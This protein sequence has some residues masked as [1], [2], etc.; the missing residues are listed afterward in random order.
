M[1]R[2]PPSSTRTDKLFPYTPL[3]RSVDSPEPLELDSPWPSPSPGAG[4]RFSSALGTS[5]GP[6]STANA[7]PP[8]ISPDEA[9]YSPAPTPPPTSAT[10][11]THIISIFLNPPFFFGAVASLSSLI[12]RSLVQ[13]RRPGWRSDE[14]TSELQ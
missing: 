7:P 1:I 11:A 2:R 8:P 4:A 6:F 9:A 10:N 5:R 13:A 14:H 12:L 3:F